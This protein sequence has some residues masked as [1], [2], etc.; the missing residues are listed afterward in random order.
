[1]WL[2]I[3]QIFH[4]SEKKTRPSP[5][6]LHSFVILVNFFFVLFLFLIDSYDDD[7]DRICF[8]SHHEWQ[9]FIHL[10]INCLQIEPLMKDFIITAV[11]FFFWYI[12][13]LWFFFIIRTNW[14][15]G[16][17]MK[18]NHRTKTLIEIGNFSFL[19]FFSESN[20]KAKK[21]TWKLGLSFF[22]FGCCC[23][24]FFL[25]VVVYHSYRYILISIFGLVRLVCVCVCGM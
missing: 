1:M 14:L 17:W 7:D 23:F 4:H 9:S 10:V 24:F 15:N 5:L 21:K 16:E 25:L 19:I 12:T 8:L 18:K 3:F 11:F 22:W 6:I 2:L 13:I 20:G